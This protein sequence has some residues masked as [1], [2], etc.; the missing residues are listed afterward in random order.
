MSDKT[1]KNEDC[2]HQHL[3]FK[4]WGRILACIDC[5][6]QFHILNE[7]GQPDMMYMNNHLN[8]LE[9]RHG[10]FALARTTPAVK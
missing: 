10:R 7:V 4:D 1:P 8:D 3:K 6:R 9:T 2:D 5:P